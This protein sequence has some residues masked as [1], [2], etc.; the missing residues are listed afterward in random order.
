MG[1][2]FNMHILLILC[3]RGIREFSRSSRRSKYRARKKP[4]K[5][6]SHSCT[7]K[8]S[9]LAF[10]I[11]SW[12]LLSMSTSG[13]TTT[14]LPTKNCRLPSNK[15]LNYHIS[16]L[17]ND[18]VLSINTFFSLQKFVKYVLCIPCICTDF[19]FKPTTIFFHFCTF[20]WF[21]IWKYCGYFSCQILG[22]HGPHTISM[23]KF[24][25]CFVL[26]G[27]PLQILRHSNIFVKL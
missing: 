6:P 23:P 3:K 2:K 14:W 5:I 19:S 9:I 15:D 22:R 7:K 21:N 4:S 13:R 1:F 10:H 20:V 8:S 27:I 11:H 18:I 24:T 26:H 12:S 17:K 25:N 16:F